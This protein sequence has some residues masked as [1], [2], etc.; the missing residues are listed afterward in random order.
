MRSPPAATP[1]GDARLR[2]TPALRELLAPPELGPEH[3]VYPV[4]VRPGSGPPEPI[5]SMPGQERYPIEGFDRTARSLLRDGVRA[6]LLFGVPRRKDATGRE[7]SED[8]GAVVRAIRTL[9]RTVPELVVFADVCLCAY[10]PHGHC[11][12]VRDGAIDGPATRARLGEIAVAYARA[13]ADLVGP[14]ASQDG[15]VAAVRAALDAAGFPQTGILAYSAKAASALYGPFR[16]AEESA[17]A[18]GDRRGYQFDPR[19]GR[20][21]VAAFRRDAEEGADIL[22]AKPALPNL[23]ILARV[24]GES[25]LPLAAYQVSGEYAMIRAA[26]RAGWI[27]GPRVRDETLAAIQRAGADLIV[28][29]FAREI[30]RER[31]GGAG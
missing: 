26:E 19:R 13:G 3:L 30:A 20:A 1:R 7:A 8:R 24:R 12:I 16:E 22:M 11:G 2:R 23:D 31:G 25:D 4:F 9:R 27:D 14:S 17:P 28:T 5:R 10:T 29:Y 6:V 21:A 15:Q 18:F